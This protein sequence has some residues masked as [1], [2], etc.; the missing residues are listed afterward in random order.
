MNTTSCQHVIRFQDYDGTAAYAECG[1]AGATVIHYV[2]DTM[3]VC[4]PHAAETR[5]AAADLLANMAYFNR[6]HDEADYEIVIEL[7]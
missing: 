6:A 2:E 1:D 3:T 5:A 4:L 7:P